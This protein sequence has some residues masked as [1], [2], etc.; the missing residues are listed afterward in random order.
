MYAA[1][2]DFIEDWRAE[3][4]RTA[5]VLEALTDA[6]LGFSPSG[7]D[8]TVGRLAWHLVTTVPEMLART[9]LQVENVDEDAPV[10]ETALEIAEA[11]AEVSDQLTG[12]VQEQWTDE[13]LK[14]EDD[15][16]GSRWMRGLTLQVLLRH[17]IHHRAQ[18]TVLMRMAGL[19]V[20]G[21]Y[22]PA[23]EDWEDMGMTP[24]EV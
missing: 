1:I 19:R 7:Y 5:K 6:S 11:Y 13:T 4:E 23:R 17:E 12:L 18:L 10:P 20:P 3:S 22:G 2:T 16:Y 24:P 9:G 15:M 21:V 14:V 8:R